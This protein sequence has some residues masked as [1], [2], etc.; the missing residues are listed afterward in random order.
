[1]R[2]FLRPRTE[3][4]RSR[5]LAWRC[6][7]RTGPDSQSRARESERRVTWRRSRPSAETS[8]VGPAVDIYALGAVL[9][10]LLTGRPPFVGETAAETERRV[11]AEEPIPPSRLI[12]TIPRDLETICLKCLCKEPESRYPAAAELA[13]DLD[14]FLEGRPILARPLGMAARF[15]RWCRRNPA[16]TAISVLLVLGTAISTWQAVSQ[17]AKRRGLGSATG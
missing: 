11:I 12:R 14:R 16:A 2:T 6:P 4:P 3:P 17:R 1:M 8:A 10:E 15:G 7:F 9:Y 13:S 5:T